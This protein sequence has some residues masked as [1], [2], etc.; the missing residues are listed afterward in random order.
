MIKDIKKGYNRIQAFSAFYISYYFPII[1]NFGVDQEP[2]FHYSL[3]YILRNLNIGYKDDLYSYYEN[4][5]FDKFANKDFKK[6][7]DFYYLNNKNR[8]ASGKII[9]KV[10]W[11]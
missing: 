11:F 3:K 6:S 9:C 7:L 8:D 2:E 5:Y 1:P 4:M 10:S